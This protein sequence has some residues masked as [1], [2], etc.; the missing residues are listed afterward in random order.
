MKIAALCDHHCGVST[1]HLEL[2]DLHFTFRRGKKNP[3]T[4]KDKYSSAALY[5]NR[6]VEK[7]KMYGLRFSD[8]YAG[9]IGET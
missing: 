2:T 3:F 1:S 5:W 9:L 4:I 8:T 6:K 7:Q